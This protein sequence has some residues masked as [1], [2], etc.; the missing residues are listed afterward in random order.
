VIEIRHLDKV[1][2]GVLQG[3]RRGKRPEGRE[4]WG[5]LRNK[6]KGKVGKK[7]LRKPISGLRKKK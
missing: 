6:R 4:N 2:E 1:G 5:R 3:K 7:H